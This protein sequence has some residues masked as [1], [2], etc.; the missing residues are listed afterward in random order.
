M[1]K[2]DQYLG[3]YSQEIQDAIYQNQKSNA[4]S[5]YQK[6]TGVDFTEASQKINEIEI[7]LKE[8]FPQAFS[9]SINS[10]HNKQAQKVLNHVLRFLQK[11]H[12]IQAIKYYRQE[13]GLGL[14]DAKE[15]VE[16]IEKH[17]ILPATYKANPQPTNNNNIQNDNKNFIDIKMIIGFILL[18]LGLLKLTN[19]I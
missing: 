6:E 5:L 15:A 8:R 7:L 14:K 9:L 17:H 1:T 12:K 19:I 11:Q 3:N 18:I 13:T 10:S 16:Y 4:I 2:F